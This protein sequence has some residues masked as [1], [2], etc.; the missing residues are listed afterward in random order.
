MQWYED[1]LN[2]LEDKKTYNFKQREF[3][4]SEDLSTFVK[5][6]YSKP[7]IYFSNEDP[8]RIASIIYTMIKFPE[9]Q[10]LFLETYN[11]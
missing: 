5:T 4:E 2:H 9:T 1:V 10:K 6:I 8:I 3:I 7:L 11:N